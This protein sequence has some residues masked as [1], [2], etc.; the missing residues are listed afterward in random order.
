MGLKIITDDYNATV[1]RFEKTSAS[2]NSYSDYAISLG[3]KNEDGSW[4]NALLNVRFKKGVEIPDK[5]VISINNC[6]P[7][8][9]EYKGKNYI[10]WMI[11]DF[12]IVEVPEGTQDNGFV[13]VPEGTP[14]EVGWD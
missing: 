10:N 6:F 9:S 3:T 11:T 7:I 12:D 8:V 4:N 13:N 14:E 1:R 2:G 5:A